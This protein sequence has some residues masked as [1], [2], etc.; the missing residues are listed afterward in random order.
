MRKYLGALIL[1]FFVFLFSG[2]ECRADNDIVIVIDPGHGGDNY[3]TQVLDGYEKD[4]NLKVAK[5]MYERLNMYEGVEVFLTRESDKGLTLKKRAQIAEEKNA[6][7]L[8][9]LHFN[10][11]ESHLSYGAECWIPTALMIYNDKQ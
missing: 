6:D 1:I 3:G 11:S 2:M 9:S 10:A 5:A 8:I 7:Y 4:Y